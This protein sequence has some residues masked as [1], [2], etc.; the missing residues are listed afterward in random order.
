MQLRMNL[1]RMIHLSG[2]AF[3]VTLVSCSTPPPARQE[4]VQTPSWSRHD[5]A[6]FLHGS[7]S[8]EVVP[9]T[10]LRAF[11]HAYPDLFPSRDLSH[12]GLIPDPDF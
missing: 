6:F 12:L 9:E 3:L 5:M 11:I 1:S 7:M 8:T 2:A 4:T 10:V